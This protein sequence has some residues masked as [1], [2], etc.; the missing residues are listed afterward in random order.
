MA[1][2]GLMSAVIMAL[3]CVLASAAL[4][5]LVVMNAILAPSSSNPMPRLCASPV[6]AGRAAA[7]SSMLPTPLP[8]TVVSTSLAKPASSALNAYEFIM[9]IRALVVAPRSAL[10]ASLVAMAAFRIARWVEASATPPTMS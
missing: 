10:P 3:S 4:N 5:P 2:F 6:M 8:T 1:S 9:A 7:N